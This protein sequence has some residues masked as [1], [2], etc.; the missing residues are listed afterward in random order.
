MVGIYIGG[1]MA[2]SNSNV[3][4]YFLQHVPSFL[5]EDVVFVD[6]FMTTKA[7]R[8]CSCDIIKYDGKKFLDSVQ[9]WDVYLE[10][11][12]RFLKDNGIDKLI[13]LKLPYSKGFMDGDDKTL[14]NF[15]VTKNA[16]AS[17]GFISI[18]NQFETFKFVEAASQVCSHVYQYVIDPKEVTLSDYYEFENFEK[19]FFMNRH[20]CKFAPY[21]CYGLLM[22]DGV[23]NDVKTDD[24]MFRCTA[25]GDNRKWLRDIADELSDNCSLDINI[26]RKGSRKNATSVKPISQEL[27][28]FM[29][30]TTRYTAVIPPY[31]KTS[32]SWMRFAESI[33]S[34]CLPLVFETCD[35]TEVRDTFPDVCD[36]IE[37]SLLVKDFYDCEVKVKTMP[38]SSRLQLVTDIC[39]CW[40]LEKVT[41]ISEIRKQWAKVGGL[42]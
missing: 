8:Y 29:L 10:H 15:V 9:N 6:K 12:R 13:V 16:Q 1:S 23:R 26:I 42:G 40:S 35:L 33:Y 22:D 41:D 7:E 17:M 20:N 14:R 32:F 21:W 3:V 11:A 19:L 31:D 38:E 18:R 28:F 30:S 4:S 36:I 37:S 24:F 34:G 39:S 5:N 25:E 27:Y 2:S